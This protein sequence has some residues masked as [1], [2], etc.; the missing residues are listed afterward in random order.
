MKSSVIKGESKEYPCMK[1]HKDSDGIEY[2]VLFTNRNEGVCI[3]SSD[4]QDIGAFMSCWH[5]SEFKP[6]PPETKVTISN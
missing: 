5:E 1:I 2:I 4:E 6:L 3:Y